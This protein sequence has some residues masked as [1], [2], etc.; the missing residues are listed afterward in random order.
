MKAFWTGLAIGAF[1][2]APALAFGSKDTAE[3]AT[4]VTAPC[5]QQPQ[6]EP[7]YAPPNTCQPAPAH[8]QR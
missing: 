2:S 7:T 5:A 1:L 8:A 3:P 4:P 6:A